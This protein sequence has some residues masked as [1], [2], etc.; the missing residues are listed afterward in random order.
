MAESHR[1]SRKEV[2]TSGRTFL[3]VS[4]GVAANTGALGDWWQ[5]LTLGGFVGLVL[6]F[7]VV[8]WMPAQQ[9]AHE[10]S[11]KTMQSAHEGVVGSLVEGFAEQRTEDREERSRQAKVF[12]RLT[13]QMLVALTKA[14]VD[15][16]SGL[17]DNH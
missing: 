5:T 1:T 16:P 11:I 17:E 3:R 13:T 6:L 4:F 15:V 14:G 12:S 9:K 8:K 10:E 2:W 7:V